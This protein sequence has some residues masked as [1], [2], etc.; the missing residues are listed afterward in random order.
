MGVMAMAISMMF[1][2]GK[3][4]VMPIEKELQGIVEDFHVALGCKYKRGCIEIH[5]YLTAKA[6]EV[7]CMF[8]CGDDD[9]DRFCFKKCT[10]KIR[11]HKDNTSRTE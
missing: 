10:S 11:I 5:Q 1:Y 8:I 4:K 9:P 6:A 2:L 3:E 7:N